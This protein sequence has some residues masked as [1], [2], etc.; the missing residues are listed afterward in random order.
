MLINNNIVLQPLQENHAMPLSELVD[1]N[2][3]HLRTWFAWVDRMSGADHFRNFIVA[4]NQRAAEGSEIS[5]MIIY[6]GELA[7]RIGI[8]FIDQQNKLGGIGYWLGKEFEGNGIVTSCIPVVLQ[9]GFNQLGLNRIEIKCAT[10]NLRSKAVPERLN[11][12]FEGVIR[13]G[14]FH[15]DHFNDLFIYSMLRKDWNQNL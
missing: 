7:G 1:R 2:R 14:E 8:Y 12:T 13:E 3:S 4:S 11:F 15:I 10:T 9:I 6:K 5:F